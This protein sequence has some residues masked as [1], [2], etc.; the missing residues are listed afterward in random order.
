MQ[1]E[2]VMGLEV[3]VELAT[4]TKIFC[5]CSTEFGGEPNSHV[6][7]V[8]LGLP[9]SLPIL[10]KEV[11]NNAIKA[12]LALNCHIQRENR[13]DRK[14]YFYPDLPKDYQISQLYHP[15]CRNGY[16]DVAVNG[17]TSR[18]TLCEIHM[19]EDAGKLVHDAGGT[20]VDYNRCGVPLIEI[21]TNPDFRNAQQVV[22]FLE[23]LQ[24]MLR[25]LDVSDCKMQE[26][27]MRADVNLSVRPKGAEQLGTRTE[28]KNLNSFKAIQRAIE[29]ESK[30][31]MELVES[32]G[33]V[34]QETRRWDDEAGESYAMRSKENAQD[35][36]YFPDPDLLPVSID[37]PW[38]AQLKGLM[39]EL[40]MEK[41]ERY[42]RDMGLSEDIAKTII[43]T[44]EVAEL[45]EAVAG[46]SGDAKLTA[47]FVVGDILRLLKERGVEPENILVDAK[48][49]A[50]VVRLT[51]DGKINRNIA[52]QVIEE[53]FDHNTD[54]LQYVEGN[55]LLAIENKE[56][57]EKAVKAAI[58][59]NPKSIED[60]KTGKQKAFGFLV[61]QAMKKLSGKASPQT[62]NKLLK[63]K[64]EKID[65]AA[66]DEQEKKDREQK[67]AEE[68][69]YAVKEWNI[70]I[71]DSEFDGCYRTANCNQLTLTNAGNE[72]KLAG[73]VR[74]IRNHGGI[75]FIDLRD[76]YGV[77]QVVVTESMVERLNKE[78]VIS[79]TG[80]VLKRDEETVN[81]KIA[82]GEVEVKASAI[83][84]LGI[85]QNNLPFEIDSSL[86]T[87]EDVRLRYRFLDLR[88]PKVHDKMIFRSKIIKYLRR[89]ME[90]LE[91]MEIQTPIL[92]NSSPEGARDYLVPSRKHKGAFYA[93]PQA[94]QQFK[95]MLMASGFDRYFQIAPCFR[96]EDA[97]ADR[98][99]GEFYQLDFEMAFATQEDVFEVAE[100][101]LYST[102]KEFSS[103]EVS[104]PPFRKITFEESMLKYGN[105]KPDLRNP[106]VITELSD[107]FEAVDFT[108]FKGRIV[109]AIR[110]PGKAKMPKSFFEKMEAYAK[111]I[112]MKGLGYITVNEDRTYKGPIDKFFTQEQRIRLAEREGLQPDDILY[113]IS[114]EKNVVAKYAGLIRT[115]VAARLNL[116]DKGRYEFCYITDFPMY[117]Y[118]EELGKI[119]FTHNPFSMPQG[120]M[121]SLLEMNPLD[122][123]A[124]QYDIVVNGVELS[125]GAV[126]NHRP[127]V[128]VKAFEIAGYTEEDV[129]NKFGA[130]YKAFQYGAP[131]H[132]GMAPGVDRM[133]MLLAEEDGIREI[134]PFPLAANGQD[135]LFNSPSPVEELQL[136][137]VH[138]KLR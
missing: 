15:I 109:R 93:L 2:I 17:E 33:I 48:K 21:V 37:E 61:G 66:T 106:L 95:Q 78:T 77:T 59:E 100:K 105:D 80:T 91:F 67:A 127:D 5:G 31:Q 63:E 110:V 58:E 133:V 53:V 75:A 112:G 76:H 3:H 27:S 64:L 16:M 11:V 7:P 118:N 138:I 19:E 71:D 114:D 137:E 20:L 50:S 103:L 84:I 25:Y 135:M 54:P 24:Q 22:A 69:K 45:F 1:Y 28:M 42:Q 125:S 46:K 124:Y 6:C 94:P 128:M 73:W 57:I 96:D 34:T 43:A 119:D 8:C 102:F 74:N 132:A 115:E 12:G 14:N 108:P 47:N 35:Y 134:I 121:K 10:N 81:S 44:K 113:F 87:R 92:G 65:L 70:S 89:Q 98:S 123:K 9:G 104:K 88:N 97:R 32:G 86:E 55:G 107:F 18:I 101:V 83:R 4:K 60:Y 38:I 51:V 40:P 52:K 39:P 129:K 82:T 117:K 131:P 62:I 122:I 126:R 13:F 41:K 72:V 136:R 116:I 49:L 23:N 130:L 56:L 120:E 29:F 111:S 36:R 30:R 26:G 90:D 85:A 79:V 68:K 99:P